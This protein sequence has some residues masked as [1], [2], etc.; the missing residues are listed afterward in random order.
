MTCS[1]L[2]LKTVLRY[3]GINTSINSYGKVH[4]S[5][6]I[7]INFIKDLCVSIAQFGQSK[8]IISMNRKI[9]QDHTKILL[10]E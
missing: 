5:R 1:R 2:K 6:L 7:M 3:L 10:F 9:S 4:R 8:D